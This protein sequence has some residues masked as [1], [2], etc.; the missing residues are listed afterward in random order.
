MKKEKYRFT[1]Y[2]TVDETQITKINEILNDLKGIVKKHD[3]DWIISITSHDGKS[4]T[5]TSDHLTLEYVDDLSN[6]LND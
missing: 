4:L 2:G 6:W 5:C 1:I 3:K